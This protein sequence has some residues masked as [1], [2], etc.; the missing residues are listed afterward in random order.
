MTDMAVLEHAVRD[1]FNRE[2]ARRLAVLR[3]V[4]VVLLNY[5]EGQVEE[6]DA[7][8]NPENPASGTRKIPFGRE[9]FIVYE[10]FM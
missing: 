7:I 3:P 4:R 10:E 6:L 2:V 8:N 5:P 1:E 9:L